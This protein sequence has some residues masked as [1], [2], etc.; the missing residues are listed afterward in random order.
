MSYVDMSADVLG[1]I[2]SERLGACAVVGHCIGGKVAM[3]MALMSPRSVDTLCVIEA[4]PT[5]FLDPWSHQL[6]TMRRSLE[7]NGGS[8][9]LA[10][11]EAAAGG[12]LLSRFMLPQAA[13]ENAYVDWRCNLSAIAPLMPELREFPTALRDRRCTL[14]LHA[15]LGADSAFVRPADAG[16]YLPM[17]PRAKVECIEAA[18]HWVHAA[19]PEALALRLRTLLAPSAFSAMA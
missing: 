19:R 18:S 4:A 12:S 2:E 17:F 8:A 6:R 16:A 14:T 3:A 10:A 15:I 7:V 1:L 9:A 11:C 5:T 13:I